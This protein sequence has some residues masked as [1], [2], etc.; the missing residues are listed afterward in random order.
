[1][2]WNLDEVKRVNFTRLEQEAMRLIR[3]HAQNN[4]ELEKDLF[5]FIEMIQE[6]R[7]HNDD[8]RSL[9]FDLANKI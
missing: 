3:K 6:E 1:M 9:A 5:S 2:V 8:I 4:K 7:R